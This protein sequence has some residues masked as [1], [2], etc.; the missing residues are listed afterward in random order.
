LAQKGSDRDK[1]GAATRALVAH[2]ERIGEL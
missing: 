1:K 2:N